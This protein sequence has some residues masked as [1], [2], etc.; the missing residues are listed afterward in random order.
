MA[1]RQ[2]E[3]EKRQCLS[4]LTWSAD[5]TPSPAPTGGPSI[6]SSPPPSPLRLLLLL[7]LLLLESVSLEPVS[8]AWP[9]LLSLALDSSE[10]RL[11]STA[12]VC[13]R[14]EHCKRLVRPRKRLIQWVK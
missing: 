3:C 12:G 10:P 14:H 1:E 8:A 9:A 11:P 13:W 5:S 2:R 4:E 6:G 7:L